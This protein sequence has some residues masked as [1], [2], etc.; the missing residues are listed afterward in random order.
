MQRVAGSGRGVAESAYGLCFPKYSKNVFPIRFRFPS[1]G[2]HIFI[3]EMCL[4]QANSSPRVENS[5]G[6]PTGSTIC[7]LRIVVS[8]PEINSAEVL[9]YH[10]L[11]MMIL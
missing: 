4:P 10:S 8:Y 3:V 6:S 11:R 9:T 1:V 7:P 2:L 5:I